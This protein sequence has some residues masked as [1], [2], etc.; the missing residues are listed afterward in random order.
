MLAS[1]RKVEELTNYNQVNAYLEL[2]WALIAVYTT[3][4]HTEGPA[5]NHQTP[6]YIIGWM[7]GEPKYPEPV[8]RSGNP[9]D[10]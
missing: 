8:K 5:A 4:Y 7:N 6:H 1:V 3:A 9:F 10:Y 2:G